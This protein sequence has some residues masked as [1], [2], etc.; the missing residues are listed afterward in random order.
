MKKVPY[1]CRVLTEVCLE[2][3]G[4]TWEGDRAPREDPNRW[5]TALHVGGVQ[6]IFIHEYLFISQLDN[7]TEL[8][9]LYSL[10]HRTL[11]PTLLK[12]SPG[13]ISW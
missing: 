6:Y 5:G 2:S 10:S 8:Y 4:G 12:F 13:S 9:R 7:D 1:E 3:L 11:Q